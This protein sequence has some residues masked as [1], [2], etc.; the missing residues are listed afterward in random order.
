[1]IFRLEAWIIC[2]PPDKGRNWLSSYR[3]AARTIGSSDDVSMDIREAFDLRHGT[4]SMSWIVRPPPE[5]PSQGQ[6]TRVAGETCASLPLHVLRIKNIAPGSVTSTPWAPRISQHWLELLLMFLHIQQRMISGCGELARIKEFVGLRSKIQ[7]VS[8]LPTR[9]SV[10]SKS[11]MRTPLKT[12][13]RM[14]YPARLEAL[15]V[16]HKVPS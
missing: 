10:P 7:L 11:S 13:W 14:M 15:S 6:S 9:V 4:H 2:F 3:S 8:T 12:R 5:G 16:R 1:L